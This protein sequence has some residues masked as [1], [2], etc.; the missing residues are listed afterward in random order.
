MKTLNLKLS[1]VLAALFLIGFETTYSQSSQ[2]TS[3]SQVE[4]ILT[5]SLSY[6]Y[7]T[8][9]SGNYNPKLPAG[10]FSQKAEDWATARNII[11]D[12]AFLNSYQTERLGRKI[13][14]WAYAAHMELNFYN[15]ET[16]SSPPSVGSGSDSLMAVIIAKHGEPTAI[17]S[18]TY[19]SGQKAIVNWYG[20]I[21]LIV[22]KNDN[23]ESLGGFPSL[24]LGD[25]ILMAHYNE[26]I[27]ARMAKI[28]KKLIGK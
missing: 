13:S 23:V 8:S 28:K 7:V 18:F 5:V 14:N 4:D 17:T 22:D 3:F 19:S 20:P 15:E 26:N 12:P 16:Q 27:K 11:I 2:S 10:F 21:F 9:Y 6:D 25:E 24:L 1:V